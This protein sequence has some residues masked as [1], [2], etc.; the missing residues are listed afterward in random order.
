[1]E[2][3]YMSTAKAFD[4]EYGNRLVY[5]DTGQRNGH[6]HRAS[7]KSCIKHLAVYESNDNQMP[8]HLDKL[9]S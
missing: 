6:H 9:S 5:G 4:I 2:Y 1:M 3:E 7:V 8:T